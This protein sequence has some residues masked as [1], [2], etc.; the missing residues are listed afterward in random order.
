[1]VA[2]Q[3]ICIMVKRYHKMFVDMIF[4]RE[5]YILHGSL[6][7]RWVTVFDIFYAAVCVILTLKI[8]KFFTCVLITFA[9]KEKE[10]LSAV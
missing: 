10:L 3:E 7:T 6:S 5:T 2:K 9:Y 1:M 8:V 4:K